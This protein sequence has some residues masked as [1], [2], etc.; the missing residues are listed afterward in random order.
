VDGSDIDN[1]TLI[2]LLAAPSLVASSPRTAR[3]LICRG[4]A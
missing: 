4:S 2:G 3:F 1:L